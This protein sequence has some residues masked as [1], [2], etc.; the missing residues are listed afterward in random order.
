MADKTS[1]QESAQAL[2]C[3]L[4]DFS[5]ASK[6]TKTFDEKLYPSYLAFKKMWD[7]SNPTAK[8]EISFKSHVEAP[9]VTLELLEKFLNENPDWY[10][11][12]LLI[13]KKL[14]E[15]IDQIGNKFS[16]I[17]RPSWSEIFYVRGDK[18][19]MKN[20][21]ELFKLANT[22][23]KKINSIP[24]IQKTVIFGNVNKWSPADIYFASDKAKKQ[25]QNTLDGNLEGFSFTDLN[26]LV[27][28]LIDSG[29]LLPLSLKKQTKRVFIQKVN[30]DRLHELKTIQKY[31]YNGTSDWKLYTVQ[32]PQ[33]RDLK[34]FIDDGKKDHMKA[35]HDASS[36]SFKVDFQVANAQARGGS[37]GSAGIFSDILDAVDSKF[38]KK[39]LQLYD[40]ANETY[41]KE[42][43]SL[44]PKPTNEKA[45]KAYD[46]ERGKIS[47]LYVTNVIFP[48]LIDWLEKGKKNQRTDRFVRLAYA[49]ITSRTDASSKFVIA[50]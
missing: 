47:A 18:S 46:E 49:Y 9:G 38:A 24:G 2:F 22:E 8:I 27:S 1:I 35:R 14:I 41:K 42:L 5:G 16:R 15:D 6:V 43:K 4:A 48:P 11:S 36:I 34:I 20:I 37:I 10:L 40:K 30:F 13:A 45:K 23:Q 50:K 12:S 33:T 25:I 17:K 3:A 21:E 32:K 44:G 26:I 39:W 28:N 7:E 29:D 31:Y 19:V